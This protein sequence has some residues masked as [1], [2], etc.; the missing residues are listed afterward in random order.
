MPRY[1]EADARDAVAESHSY[2]EALTRL[3]LRPAGGNH[4]LFRRY[5]DSIWKIDTHHFDPYFSSRRPNRVTSAKPLEEVLVE[6]STYPREA[7]K[8]R[9]YA[10]GLKRPICELCGQDEHWNGRRM[11]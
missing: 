8:P 5:V 7:L 3:G 2:A 6:R 10:S 4:A 1:S 11:A 9:L